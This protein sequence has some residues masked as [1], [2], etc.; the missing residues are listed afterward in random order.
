MAGI[1]ARMTREKRDRELRLTKEIKSSKCNYLLQPF[2]EFYE[3][4]IHNKVRKDSKFRSLSLMYS[5]K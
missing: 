3:P 4:S 5:V 1:I 2:P